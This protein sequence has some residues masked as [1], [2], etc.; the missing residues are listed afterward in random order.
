MKKYLISGFDTVQDVKLEAGTYTLVAYAKSMYSD[1]YTFALGDGEN[2]TEYDIDVIKGQLCKVWLTFT[3]DKKATKFK[4]IANNFSES[5]PVYVADLQLTK[6]NIPV[7]AGASPFDIDKILDDLHDGIDSIEDFTNEAFADGLLNREEKT[8]LRASLDAI[9]SIVESVKGS[10]N[11]L[12]DNPFIH[13]GTMASIT[14][15]YYDFIAS[16][17]SDGDPRGL[18]P[19]ILWIVNGD[20]IISQNERDEKDR[21]LNA[22]NEALYE[23]NQA[24]KEVYND[25]GEN[26]VAPVIIDGFWA[27]WNSE[28]QEFVKSEFSA[29]GDD[30]HSPYIN[31]TTGTWWEWSP[32][33]GEFKNT[34]I[35]AEGKDAVNIIMSPTSHSFATT[36]NGNAKP[37]SVY[38]SIKA[39]RGETP[40]T[41]S[42]S[43][44]SVSGFV[45]YGMS[46]TKGTNQVVLTV[47]SSFT[48]IP[49]G[50]DIYVTI[51]SVSYLLVFLWD[52]VKDGE[53]G[54]DGDGIVSTTIHYAKSSNGN[55]SP[56]SGWGTSLPTPTQGWYLWT[57]TTTTYKVAETTVSYSV[58]HWA[59]DGD[60]IVSTTIE[61][62][63]R[64]SGTTI[65][66]SGWSTS[67]PSP[68]KGWYLWTR[69]TTVYKLSPTTV[70]YSTSYW[71]EDGDD[72]KG[73]S[74]VVTWYYKSSSATE[75]Q[76][77]SWST[78]K[79]SYSTS[80]YLWTKT[81]TTYTD[82]SES[83]TT[84][85]LDPDWHKVMAITDKF[86][87]TIDGGL[88]TTVMM[89]L[90]E[91]NSATVT[92]GISGLQGTNK[93]DVAIWAGGTDV[94]AIRFKDLLASFR[95]NTSFP[96]DKIAN[97]VV[98]HDGA[99]KLGSIFIDERGVLNI[100]DPATR[101][102]VL[103][104]TDKEIPTFSQLKQ[105]I[106]MSSTGNNTAR[107]LTITSQDFVSILPTKIVVAKD[108][109]NLTIGGSATLKSTLQSMGF[110]KVQVQLYRNGTGFYR[111]IQ[112]YSLHNDWFGPPRP[113]QT[114]QQTLSLNTTIEDIQAGTYE[115]RVKASP[116]FAS[117]TTFAM[118]ATT[119]S[120]NFA[121]GDPNR[122]QFGSNGFFGWF[123]DRYIYFSKQEGFKT[124]GSESD[125]GLIGGGYVLE[126]G[127]LFSKFG[128]YKDGL[129]TEPPQEDGHYRIIHN[130]GHQNYTL[131][132]TPRVLGR[133][134][135]I[136][137]KSNNSIEIMCQT[138]L[139]VNMGVSFDFQIMGEM[140][141]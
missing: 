74:S 122:L 13:E 27:F 128:K 114:M 10:Y 123:G 87:T 34:F 6:G 17:I 81:I 115:I 98:N 47:N 119:M 133:L 140:P 66:T 70:A 91:A 102:A 118:T 75:L 110:V 62:V 132:V 37:R 112:Q 108:G 9:G 111:D 129:S 18:K 105:N 58:S 69:T 68:T 29:I 42:A 53:D 90:R 26:S 79:P 2:W 23:Y 15:R 50:I 48:P 125:V 14:A 46:V 80:F 65:P 100:L 89:L 116:I 95:N 44:I 20:N 59:E 22:F 39:T 16:W 36:P 127:T 77:G 24:E 56:S 120:W 45:P 72:G 104:I 30:G 8:Q 73:V 4:P 88:I 85:I 52:S 131:T 12:L 25:V 106:P 41:I 136:K 130:I 38:L 28:L 32:E 109:G 84:P 57:R 1:V 64:S 97:F 141:I 101:K 99:M 138:R 134:I 126:N 86:G 139:G 51:N 92:A 7:E 83:E 137:T 96:T 103:Q 49:E 117:N 135:H 55:T 76:G 107:T 61:Y 78:T 93:D 121:G 63:K 3:I 67:I 19:V 82:N 71:A 94:D 5:L 33:I 40:I 35:K 31:T 113:A 124:S 54:E 43:Q 60:G 11:K 21:A